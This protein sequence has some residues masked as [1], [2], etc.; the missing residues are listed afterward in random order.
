MSHHLHSYLALGDSYTIGE[1]LPLH[2]SFPYQLIQLLR[3]KGLHFYA[4]EIVAQTGW[5]TSELAEHLLHHQLNEK[6]DFATLLIGVNNQYRGLSIE[7]Y[8]TD[9]EFLLRKAVHYAG[10]ISDHVFILSIPDYSKTPFVK[11]KDTH[12]IET[13]INAYNELNKNIAQQQKVQYISITDESK[14]TAKDKSLLAADGLHYSAVAYKTWA[15]SIAEKISELI[16][17]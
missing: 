10:G 14:K 17:H 11:G 13:E 15:E 2:E 9:F 1:G 6:Y 12:K 4:P 16:K 8:K 5:T 7:D 3:E